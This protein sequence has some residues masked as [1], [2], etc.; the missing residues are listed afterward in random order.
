MHYCLLTIPF[1]IISMIGDMLARKKNILKYV[2]IFQPLTTFIAAIAAALSLFMPEHQLRYTIPIL[3]GLL[4]STYADSILVNR[5]D[6]S[7]LIKGM[8]IFFLALL[9]YGITLTAFN[10]FHKADIII[11]GI[12]L[13]FYSL[14]MIGFIRKTE[15]KMS[16][17]ARIPAM[18][19]AA[20]FCF[21][22]SRAISCFY[23]TEFSKAQA[24]LLTVGTISFFLGDL[25][26][27][28]YQYINK[29][30]PMFQAPPFY[31]VGQLLIGLSASYFA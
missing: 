16:M 26:L 23:G 1:F 22:I 15:G 18:I 12:L 3:I 27:G 20:N 17:K 13:I 2:K 19:Y 28:I 9:I 6:K 30:F 7:A 14:L 24:I 5:D 25:Q 31:F 21:V 10:G 8:L 4:V 29:K 11:C